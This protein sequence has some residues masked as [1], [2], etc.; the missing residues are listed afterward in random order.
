MSVSVNG[1]SVEQALSCAKG[2]FPIVRHNEIRDLTAN[3][4]IEVCKDVSVEPELQ[5]VQPQQL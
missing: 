2:G 3:M 4:L 1:M 5:P